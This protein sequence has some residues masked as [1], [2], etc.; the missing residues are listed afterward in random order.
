MPSGGQHETAMVG[1]DTCGHPVRQA[2]DAQRQRPGPRPARAPREREALLH[3]RRTTGIPLRYP[4]ASI[5]DT[6]RARRRWRRPDRAEASAITVAAQPQ[7]PRHRARV[8]DRAATREACPHG[9]IAIPEH[10]TALHLMR[11]PAAI[12]CSQRARDHTARRHRQGAQ[13]PLGLTGSRQRPRRRRAL[14][15][16]AATRAPRRL[17]RTAQARPPTPPNGPRARGP[18]GPTRKARLRSCSGCRLPS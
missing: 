18:L 10:E 5:D 13:P 17:T 11:E 16:A 2:P 7:R 15:A 3:P 8:D 1:P 12:V 6:V 14:C 4:T 9:G